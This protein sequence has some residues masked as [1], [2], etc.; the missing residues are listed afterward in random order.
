[1]KR[2]SFLRNVTLGGAAVANFLYPGLTNIVKA[3]NENP[4]TPSVEERPDRDPNFFGGTVVE[5][6]PEGIVL[7]GGDELK[8][9]RIS[10]ET[11]VW[12]EFDGNHPIRVGDYADVRGTALPDGTLQA[13]SI[14]VNIGRLD[15]IIETKTPSGLTIATWRGSKRGIEFSTQLVAL[16]SRL[17]TTS[18]NAMSLSLVV[19]PDQVVVWWIK[20]HS[21]ADLLLLLAVSCSSSQVDEKRVSPETYRFS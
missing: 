8:A 9:I 16:F 4:S 18:L 11:A 5:Q 19:A 7:A 3:Q 17:P 2:R 15:G 10:E 20:R 13:E 21:A 6:T 1:M 14:W 12:K